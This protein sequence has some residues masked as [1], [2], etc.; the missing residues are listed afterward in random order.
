[1]IP[2]TDGPSGEGSSDVAFAVPVLGG[3][4]IMLFNVLVAVL[5]T[6]FCFVFVLMEI[7]GRV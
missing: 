7:S 6:L 1:M 3:L 4:S 2:A 5:E